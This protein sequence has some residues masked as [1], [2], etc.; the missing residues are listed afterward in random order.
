MKTAI[1]ALLL[2]F[3]GDQGVARPQAA[4]DGFEA[5]LALDQRVAGIA[6]RLATGNLGL[7][8]DRAFLPGFSI[9]DLSQYDSATRAE[10]IR[11]FGL[12]LGPAV[13]ATAPGGPA[14]R[15]GLRH[16]DVLLSI[17]GRS[18]PRA[19]ALPRQGSFGHME[20]LLD[21][22]E[23]AIA[24]GRASFAVRRAGALLEFTVIADEGCAS[25][26]ELMPGRRLRA[27]ADGRYVQVTSAIAA[28]V[29]DDDELAS[30]LAHELAHN[31]LRHRLRLDAADVE[32]GI[33]GNFG[34]NARQ[35]RETEVEADR[36]SVYL[37]ERAGFGP[38]AAVR[39]WARFGRRG[40]NLFGSPTHPN[41]R[42]R[43]ALLESE[44]A[45]IARARAAGETPSPGFVSLPLPPRG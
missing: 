30:V 32:R 25:R 45:A 22:L 10:A 26:F 33:L 31:V 43:I 14:E 19:G 12:E 37:M 16:G 15:S 23:E 27:R 21:T 34:R 28:Y 20:R 24:D 36:L 1:L 8:A 3:G 5:T 7:C 9:H 40:L 44:I 42:R 38:R 4:P 39:F 11:R 18:L 2:A 13:L 17:D 6:H 35:I 41:W 29:R